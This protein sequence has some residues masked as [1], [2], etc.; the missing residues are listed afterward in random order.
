MELEATQFVPLV[1]VQAANLRS[2]CSIP[3]GLSNVR[4]A[5]DFTT[6]PLFTHFLFYVGLLGFDLKTK[7][8]MAEIFAQRF[9]F[10]KKYI[11]RVKKTMSKIIYL[12]DNHIGTL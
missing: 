5:T 12:L 8:N 11:N 9:W 7:N 1:R 6:R 2:I 3:R 4:S 10:E